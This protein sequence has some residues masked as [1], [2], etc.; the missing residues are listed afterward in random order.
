[1]AVGLQSPRW[2]LLQQAEPLY[3]R[4]LDAKERTL[5]GKHPETLISVSSLASLL[6]D[7]GKLDQAEPLL[8]RALDAREKTLGGEHPDTL[9]SVNNLA[10]LLQAQGKFDQ[11][12]AAF[13]TACADMH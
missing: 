13:R 5:G 2:P 10:S 9:Q 11:V 7:Q 12:S 8:C 3:R 6:Q 4:A 1:M